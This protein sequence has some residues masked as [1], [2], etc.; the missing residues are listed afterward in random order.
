MAGDQG[1]TFMAKRQEMLHRG[2]RAVLI[3]HR[4]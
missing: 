1:E 3:I 4:N 2:V